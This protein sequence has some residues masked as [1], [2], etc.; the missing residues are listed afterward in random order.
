MGVHEVRLIGTNTDP[1][2]EALA[3]PVG[4]NQRA[5]AST[6]AGYP[7]RMGRFWLSNEVEGSSPSMTSATYRY[8]SSD[9]ARPHSL[10]RQPQFRGHRPQG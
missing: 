3:Q 7:Q 2:A 4:G 6:G 9:Q 10:L 1:R 8:A 5:R